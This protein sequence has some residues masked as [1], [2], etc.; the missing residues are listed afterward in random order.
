MEEAEA[1][2]EEAEEEVGAP[3]E[4]KINVKNVSKST[5]R[6]SAGWKMPSATDVERP[7][8]WEDQSCARKIR[9]SRR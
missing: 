8:T 2:E 7:V 4:P 9:K 5:G 6:K 3:E 1:E